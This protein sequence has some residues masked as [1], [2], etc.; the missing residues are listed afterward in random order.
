MP[1]SYSEHI[2]DIG[3][4]AVGA[5][6]ASAFEAGVEATLNIMFDLDAIEE[7]VCVEVRAEAGDVETLFVEVINEVLSLQGRD[8]LAL[9]R[10]K[11]E[12]IS[13][14]DG[15]ALRGKAFG[16]SFDA[17]R[18]GPGTEVKG[19]TYSGLFY[20]NGEGG[21]HVLRCVLDV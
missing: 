13:T 6:L 7:K 20:N 18:H 17:A 5:D 3:I 21:V 9:R 12:E 19:A 11:V 15:F 2:S 14:G 4:E 16:E 8:E 10:L 1:Y